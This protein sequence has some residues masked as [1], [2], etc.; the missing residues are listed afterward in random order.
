MFSELKIGSKITVLLLIVVL[1]SVFAISVLS[2]TVSRESIENRYAE[3]LKVISK[4]KVQELEEIFEELEQN[5]FFIQKSEK[6]V[7]SLNLYSK[8]SSKVEIYEEVKEDLHDYLSSVQ[9]VDNYKNILL[10]DKNGKIIYQSNSK[11]EK[12]VGSF[13]SKF[14]LYK[15]QIGEDIF[16]GEPYESQENIYLDVIGNIYRHGVHLGYA[17]AE[18]NMEEIY[19]VTND[20][21]GLRNT[22][23]ILIGKKTASQRTLIFL[24]QK[25]GSKSKNFLNDLITVDD[26]N[27][28]TLQKAVEGDEGGGFALDYRGK[29]TL[30]EWK[31]LP[32][33]GWGMIVKIDKEEISEELDFLIFTFLFSSVFIIF[34]SWAVARLYSQYLITPLLSLKNTLN[35]VARGILPREVTRKTNDEIG[36]MAT[37]VGEFVNAL[38]RTAEFAHQIGEG[39]YNTQFKPLDKEDT[40]GN[41][42]ITMRNNIQNSEKKDNERNWIVIGVA[43]VG[44]ILRV[45]NDLQEMGDDVIAYI[46][47]KISAVQGA[48][49]SVSE[50]ENGEQIIEMNASYAYSK[51]KHFKKTFK[52]AEGLV[53]QAAIEQDTILRTEIPDDYM[54]ITSGLLGEQKPKCLLIVPLITNETVFGVLEFAG[55]QRFSQTHINFVQEL[56]VIIARTIFNIKV[57]ARTARLLEE[58]QQMSAELRAQQEI[59][60]QNAEEM[61][62]TQEQLKKANTRLEEQ[63]LEVKLAQKRTQILLENASEVITIYEKDGRVRYISPSVETILGYVPED[64]IGKNDIINVLGAGVDLVNNMFDQLL[65]EPEETLT[66]QFEYR[67]KDRQT[68]WLEATGTNLL[69]DQ[70]IGGIVVNSRDIT[71][72]R[73]AEQEARM[74]GQM[75]SLSENSPDLITRMNEKGKVFYINPTIRHLTGL[76]PKNFLGKSIQ[77]VGLDEKIVHHWNALIGEALQRGSNVKLE[78]P[79]PS[80]MGERIMQVNG[81]PEYSTENKELESILIV[82]HDITEQKQTESALLTINKKITES[83]N[84]AQRIQSAILPDAAILKQ[85]LK[86]SFIYYLP[87]D[88]VSGDFPWF[89]QKGEN[90]FIAAVDCTGHGVPGALISLIGYFLL[91][92]ILNAQDASDTGLILDLLNEGVTKTLRQDTNSSTRDGM[93]IALCRI[94]LGKKQLQYSGAHRP[95]YHVRKGTLTQINGDRY[96]I[97]GGQY[98]TRNNFKSEI[99]DLLKEDSVYFFSDGL[100]DQF[101]GKDNKKFSPA[102]IRNIFVQNH[103]LSMNEMAKVLDQNLRDWMGNRKQMDDILAIGIKF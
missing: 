72:R 26:E 7:H 38:K 18:F 47:N 53:G 102:K 6:V 35:V 3:G 30:T 48:F 83:I 46:T 51:K 92:D 12:K 25:R 89:A 93:D 15:D 10:L 45:H 98:K 24:N 36:E 58:S 44:Q 54:H 73:L 41:A 42:L 62:V 29:L 28:L 61:E 56:S 71:E 33:V 78:M 60:R 70:A 20:T 87:R 63:I 79:F 103:E 68:I 94:N 11:A 97:G 14:A 96:P 32:S 86:D 2:Y 4:L 52:F 91:N 81:I 37:A 9:E 100:P 95:L 27:A 23:E 65:K 67:K 66:I 21:T 34:I 39:K 19:Q 31:H 13:Y 55:L 8:D 82:S 43:E 16:F 40:L 69:A 59:L 101:G 80:V 77:E 1:L 99:I 64:L 5:I 75:Q 17:V 57:N 74:R 22:G 50:N 84:Y 49:Y 88:V 76:T 85:A 90:I